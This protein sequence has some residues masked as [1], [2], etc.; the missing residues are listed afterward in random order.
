MEQ[1]RICYAATGIAFFIE[2][3]FIKRS[4]FKLLGTISAVFLFFTKV[5]L[6]FPLYMRR[7]KVFC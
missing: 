5:S 1:L 6:F 7:L 2:I 4:R 3:V